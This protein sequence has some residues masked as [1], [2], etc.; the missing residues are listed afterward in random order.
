MRTLDPVQAELDY[1]LAVE[2][3]HYSEAA[4]IVTD[5]NTAVAAQEARDRRIGV[6]IMGTSAALWVT[7]ITIAVHLVTQVLP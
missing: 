1:M 4:R 7:A 3:G 6:A 5:W 2:A